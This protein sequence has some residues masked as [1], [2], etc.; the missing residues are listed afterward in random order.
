MDD[1]SGPKKLADL[2]VV[3]LRAE[4]ETRGLDKSGVKVTLM[5]R[6][7]QVASLLHCFIW[8]FL[9]CEVGAARYV[10][11]CLDIS[12]LLL[13]NRLPRII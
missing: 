5:E 8:F 1:N 2:R 7:K 12:I 11:L 10:S 13:V 3:D 9:E 6:L 4:L